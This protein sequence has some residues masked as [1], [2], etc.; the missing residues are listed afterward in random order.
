M[1]VIKGKT[2][3]VELMALG[4]NPW[5]QFGTEKEM[6]KENELT[7][8]EVMCNLSKEENE[9]LVDP[10]AFG[11]PSSFK[12]NLEERYSFYRR[13]N[14]PLFDHELPSIEDIN[15]INQ[16]FR[17]GSTDF[18][19]FILELRYYTPKEGLKLDE[20]Y[21]RQ[22]VADVEGYMV[23]ITV[24]PILK[25]LL[26]KHGS[27]LFGGGH[28]SLTCGMKS[29]TATLLCVVIDR[30]Y[31]TNIED[32]TR[33]DLKDWFFCLKAIKEITDFG[34][35][36][37]D[38]FLETVIVPAFL[39]S[40]AIRYE[41]DISEKLDLRITNLEAALERTKEARRIF[42]TQTSKRPD[43]VKDY[44]ISEALKWKGKKVNETTSSGVKI[45]E[46]AL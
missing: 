13:E 23:P 36:G 6:L 32:I 25:T 5:Y 7:L 42:K 9:R 10:Y 38:N 2:T 4:E 39:G 14:S 16:F 19:N 44:V 8:R 1:K 12:T 28:A 34:I 15:R 26:H 40:E 18:L 37:L 3:E 22:K 20:R 24:A 46:Y 31:N 33:D 35:L 41:K 27:D 45:T 29:V 11:H 21:L 43:E 30:I 17:F